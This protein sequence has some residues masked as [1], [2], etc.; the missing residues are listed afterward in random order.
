MTDLYAETIAAWTG[1]AAVGRSLVEE[2]ERDLKAA[3]LP[4]LGWYDALLE[5]ER[6]APDGVRPHD[7]GARLLLPQYG[8]SRLLDRMVRAELIVKKTCYTDGRGQWIFIT[9]Q[10]RKMRQRMWPVY[11]AA[12]RRNLQERLSVSELESLAALTKKLRA[13]T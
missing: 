5:I 10:G 11:E 6:A 12:L 7:L 4:P 2:I 1:L 9:E 13:T 8:A 3:D